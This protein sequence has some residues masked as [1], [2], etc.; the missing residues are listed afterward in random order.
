MVQT[1]PGVCQRRTWTVAHRDRTENTTGVP[2]F[3]GFGIA[4][5]ESGPGRSF[6]FAYSSDGNS[7]LCVTGEGLLKSWK[8]PEK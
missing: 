7:V 6:R 4:V 5:T 3:T 2:A 8:L 1:V